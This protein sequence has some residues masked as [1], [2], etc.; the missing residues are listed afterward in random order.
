[1]KYV[2]RKNRYPLRL[3]KSRQQ[4]PPGITISFGSQWSALYISIKHEGYSWTQQSFTYSVTSR[5]F[6]WRSVLPVTLIRSS[7]PS[8]CSIYSLGL[9]TGRCWKVFWS[10]EEQVITIQRPGKC[11]Q[12]V[13]FPLFG[14]IISHTT[15]Q[16]GSRRKDRIGNGSSSIDHSF[17][18]P[19]TNR[20]HFQAPPRTIFPFQV[21]CYIAADRRTRWTSWWWLTD[22]PWTNAD[23]ICKGDMSW[24]DCG[25]TFVRI[26]N[27]SQVINVCAQMNKYLSNLNWTGQWRRCIEY[28]QSR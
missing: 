10:Q 7:Q 12:Q 4:Q 9:S 25:A 2:F 22:C 17:I 24:T 26:L 5:T 18:P 11:I 13:H 28:I 1:M 6:S 21:S 27:G 20:P 19:G 15:Q 14:P 3:D 8:H 16:K 23:N